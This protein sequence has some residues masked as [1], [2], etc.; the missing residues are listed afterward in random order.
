M[1]RETG[2]EPATPTLARSCSTTELFPP[3]SGTVPT[4]PCRLLV[5]PRERVSRWPHLGQILATC[6][7]VSETAGG[8]AVRPRRRGRRLRQATWLELLPCRLR[9][10][11][12]PRL[13]LRD[14]PTTYAGARIATKW[15][16]VGRSGRGRSVAQVST[17]RRAGRVIDTYMVLST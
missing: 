6:S 15:S 9:V 7:T 17:S 12:G 10:S 1:E 3:A 14:G 4:E 8:L 16:A 13:R 5:S 11:H 2:F